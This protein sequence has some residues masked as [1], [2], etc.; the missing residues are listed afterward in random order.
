MR[1]QINLIRL[2]IKPLESKYKIQKSTKLSRICFELSYKRLECS[3]LCRD[4]G[5]TSIPPLASRSP[6]PAP[7][8]RMLYIRIPEAK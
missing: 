2:D 5:C 6:T 3:E 4:K 1:I 7:A 8:E